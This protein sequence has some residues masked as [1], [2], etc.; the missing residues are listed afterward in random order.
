LSID[1]LRARLGRNQQFNE[2]FVYSFNDL[3]AYPLIRMPVSGRNCLVAPLPPLLFRRFTEGLYYEICDEKDFGEPFGES[4]QNYTGEVISAGFRESVKVIYEF[5]YFG[6]KKER[7]DSIDWIVIDKTGVL[8]VEC[9]TRRVELKA[10]IEIVNEEALIR[11]VEKMGEFM[12][13]VYKTIHDYRTGLYDSKITYDP[14]KHHFPVIVTLEEWFFFGG[15]IEGL[16]NAKVREL[17][18]KANIPSS[19]VDDMPYS[20]CSIREF[21]AMT[22][23]MRQVGIEKIMREKTS[24]AEKR[25]WLFTPFLHACFP[26]ECKKIEFLFQSDFERLASAYE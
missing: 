23:I 8:L 21:E 12:V 20:I 15:Q 9:K 11:Q 26:D 7:K 18:T 2:N 25:K 1:E 22:Q 6:P 4:F 16:L 14:Q 24:D 19:Y 17:L 3:R 5:E 10:K 13:Q